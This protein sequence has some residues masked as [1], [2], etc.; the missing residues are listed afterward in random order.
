MKSTNPNSNQQDRSDQTRHRILEAA[1][2]EFSA[3]GLAGA[4]TDSIARSAKVNKALLYYYFK[5]K[6]SLYI[7][8]IEDMFRCWHNEGSL[9]RSGAVYS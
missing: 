6:E 4:R 3:Q 7:A 2:K 8:S 9:A 5:S 1:V